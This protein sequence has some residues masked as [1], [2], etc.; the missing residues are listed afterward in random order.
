[1]I[2]RFAS[3]PFEV[4]VEF[5]DRDGQT[6]PV[7]VI[8]PG[9]K[10]PVASK[11][12]LRENGKIIIGEHE[13]YMRS[14]RANNTPSTT[15]A[16]WKDWPNIVDVCFENREADI[17][18]FLRRH[19][20]SLKPEIVRD[21]AAAISKG[22][23]PPIDAEDLLRRYLLE[24]QERFKIVLRERNATLPDHG[25]WEVALMIEGEV[26]PHSPNREFLNLLDSSNPN[27]TGWPIWL[28][29]RGFQEKDFSPYVCEGVWET[30]IIP[31]ESLWGCD[32]DFMRLDPKGYFYLQRALQD[33]VSS[34]P[35]APKP[36]TALDFGLPIIRTAEAIAVGMAF[37]KAMGC[38]SEKT[39]M[40]F[41]FRWTRLRG[42]QLV[43][44]ANPG[45]LMSPGRKAYQDDITS[46]VRVPLET[47]LAALAEFVYRIVGPLYEVFDGFALS[48]NVVEDLTRRLIERKL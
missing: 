34:S 7:I 43:S 19:L 8:P 33:D 42:R 15:K 22:I 48:K 21:F 13:V 36:L 35:R 30:M 9:V 28:V 41:A 4:S 20:G 40:C 39:T 10:T 17:G 12:D 1:M 18:R 32:I 29:T 2:S 46:F 27:Y 16:T 23:E 3:D 25:T 37:G 38:N 24:G 14:L 6:F 44:W 26:P 31:K 11:S 47:P 5:Q 45:R